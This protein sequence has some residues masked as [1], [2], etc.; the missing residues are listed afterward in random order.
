MTSVSKMAEGGPPD[1]ETQK[2]T[3]TNLLKIPMKKDDIWYLIDSRWFKQFKKYIGFDN[4]DTLGAGEQSSFPGPIDNAPLFKEDRKAL[5]EHLIEE[6]DMVLVPEEAWKRLVSWYDT[7]EGQ[8]PIARQVVEHGMFVKQCKVEVYLVEFKLCQNNDLENYVTQQFSKADTIEHI[9]KKMRT[10]FSIEDSKE[11]RLW[12]KYMSNTYEHLNKKDH[13]VQDAGLYQG[14]VLVIEQKNEDGTWPRMKSTG[15]LGYSSLP[16]AVVTATTTTTATASA[17]VGTATSSSSGA[18]TRSQSLRSYGGS[19]GGG[20][21][22]T[23]AYGGSEGNGAGEKSASVQPGLCGLANLGNTCFMNSALQC[24]SNVRPITKYFLDERHLAEL[25]AENPLGMRG[26]IAI[27]Y[28]HL[29]KQMWSGRHG[30]TVPRDFKVAVSRFAPQF[31]GYQQHDSQELLAFL[32][33]GLHEDLNRIKKK[34]YIEL[35]DHDGRPDEEVA[36]EAWFN[37][38]QRN[39]SIIVDTFHGLLKSTLVCPEC[40]K[41]SVTFDPFCYLSLPLLP[42]KK[43][44][45]IEVFLMPAA[46]Q[47]KPKQ[48]Q[49]NSGN[50]QLFGQPTVLSVPRATCTYDDLYN[51]VLEKMRRYVR[52]PQDDDEW[53]SNSEDE[54]NGEIEMNSEEEGDVAD[55]NEIGRGRAAAKA[56]RIVANGDADNNKQQKRMFEFRI[57]NSNGSSE[58]GRFR[59][60]GKPIKFPS[61]YCPQCKKHQQATKQFDLWQLPRV[62]VIHLK[63]F[64]YNRY[65]RDKIDTL[66]EFPISGLNMA[67]NVIN[68][69]H[70][71]VVDYDLIGVTNHYGG[72]GGGHYT[73]YAKNK[74]DSHWYYFDDSSVSA[75]NEESCVSKAAY[76]LFY[77]RR[78]PSAPCERQPQ[79]IQPPRAGC[80]VAPSASAGAPNGDNSTDDEEQMDVN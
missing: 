12:N 21:Y 59:D 39:D 75:A 10:L 52:R 76:V 51:L 40:S 45:Q 62:L 38:R 13:T 18:E 19:Y 44:R 26:E 48:Q 6:V 7:V 33:D 55:G 68:P 47:G 53:C 9:E 3:I 61:E 4:W 64:S 30:Y 2:E 58:I 8:E 23:G 1:C 34:P 69:M 35:R 54:P 67:K 20:S 73:A 49:R 56:D 5:R 72:M 42:V 70:P 28:G 17:S 37:Y 78:D 46:P 60:D 65:W 24:M 57:I 16:S 25:N 29:I 50:W 31:S 41:I 11:T 43:E 74:D 14:Q 63:R 66:V 80:W 27:A 32:L 15:T 71:P 36:R 77:A 79:L 22:A